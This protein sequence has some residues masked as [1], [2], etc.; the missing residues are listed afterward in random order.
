MK[1]PFSYSNLSL[2]A[3]CA[4]RH[5]FE[6]VL[7]IKPLEQSTSPAAERGVLLHKMCED[8]TNNLIQELPP[9]LARWRPV[10]DKLRNSNTK[11]E[12]KLAVSINMEPVPYDSPD[13][14]FYGVI[15]TLE[16][17]DWMACVGD[18]KSG[19]E[20]DYTQQLKFYT[21][22]VL[23]NFP[24]LRTIKTRIR[25]I[26]LGVSASGPEFGRANLDSL[27]AEFQELATRAVSDHIH[28]PTPNVHCTWCPYSKKAM[29]ICK[30]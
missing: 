20:R 14:F 29:A 19:K 18:W 2:Y 25:Y 12:L 16:L 24:Q 21:M 22:L 23:I 9:E 8:Y 27:W 17:A 4:Q 26:D 28:A 6:R 1:P 10:L 13:A 3:A 11:S 5:Y 7:A 30:W 15:D